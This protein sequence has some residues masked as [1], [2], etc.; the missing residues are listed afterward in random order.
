MTD[1]LTAPALFLVPERHAFLVLRTDDAEVT[2]SRDFG[3]ACDEAAEVRGLVV[4]VPILADYT[5]MTPL[6]TIESPPIPFTPRP[7]RP[8]AAPV[9]APR[10]APVPPAAPDTTSGSGDD[11]GGFAVGGRANATAGGWDFRRVP[12]V[13]AFDREVPEP[14]AELEAAPAEVVSRGYAA[15]GV[16]VP[17]AAIDAMRS[18]P[19]D[20]PDV[21]LLK[22]V[23][24]GLSATLTDV[25]DPTEQIDRTPFLKAV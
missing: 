16:R 2:W 7:Q 17:P 5:H 22:R 24:D 6:Q 14:V 20:A 18:T 9:P 1:H 23:R 12:E 19:A 21:S 13:G 10:P 4:A 3:L 25:D 8:P 15:L 11:V